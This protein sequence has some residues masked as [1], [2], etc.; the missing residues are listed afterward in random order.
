MSSSDNVVTSQDPRT[1]YTTAVEAISDSLANVSIQGD[2]T[3]NSQYSPM[4]LQ[5]NSESRPFI[6]YARSQLLFL[7]KSP[8]VRL[9]S[10]MPALKDWF[11]TE[12][13]QTNGKKDLEAPVAAGNARDRRFRRDA[14]DGAS[15][16]QSFR[17]AT[18][19]Q[20]SQMGNFKHQSIRATDRDR[21]RDA[22]R[23]QDRDKVKE[24]QERLRNLSD[25]Y[26]R[27]RRAL[28]SLSQ[29][30][31]KDRELAPHLANT[32]S[33]GTSQ[34]QQTALSRVSDSRDSSRKKEGESNE[35]WRR[36]TDQPR[37]GR[38][39]NSRRDREDRDRER[40]RS[41]V[42]DSSR[43]HRDGSSSRRD[44]DDRR[45]DRDEGYGGYRR[46]LDRDSELDDP[47]RWRDDGKRDERMAARR[48]RELRDRRDRPTWDGVDRSDRRWVAGDDRD[49]RGKKPGGRDRKVGDDSKDRED[50][51]DR[52]RE[53]EP[54]WMDTYIP[55]NN[56]GG[57]IG[58]QR[59]GGEL[60]GIQAFRKEMQQKDRSTS[61]SNADV[62]TESQV[63]SASS[64]QPPE[65]QL[66]EIQLFRLM[67][68][69]EE[70]KKKSDS[71]LI[72]HSPNTAPESSSAGNQDLGSEA[73]VSAQE[74]DA[75]L[76]LAPALSNKGPSQTSSLSSARQP[77]ESAQLGADISPS[78]R[79]T[80]SPQPSVAVTFSGQEPDSTD[81]LRPSTSRLFST[82]L[83]S[84]LPA[85][86]ATVKPSVA[87]I[88]AP[89]HVPHSHPP[90]GSRLLALSS[91]TPLGSSA[92]S[93]SSQSPVSFA[94]KN[95]TIGLNTGVVAA[96]NLNHHVGEL[97]SQFSPAVE[98]VR[99]S[100]GFSP[101]DE[102]RDASA[103]STSPDTMH[104]GPVA[105]SGDRRVFA[106][107][108]SL[109]AEPGL[110]GGF[111]NSHPVQSYEPVGSG[112]AAAK[113]SRFAKFFDGKGR[114]SQPVGSSKGSI[115]TLGPSQPT[116]LQKMDVAGFPPSHNPDAR[117]MEDIFAMLNNSAQAQILNATPELSNL[118]VGYGSA[119]NIHAL[120]NSQPHT[121]LPSHAR[122]DSLYDSRLDDRNFVPD[123]MVP[124]LRSVPPPRSRQNSAM[125]SDF[126]EESMQFNNQRG[127]APMYQG[128]V[129]SIHL[130][131]GNMGR[132]GGLP[133]PATQFRGAPSPSH[134]ATPQRLPPGLA[135]LGGRPPHEP[136]QFG[137]S[138]IGMT[139]GGL[140]GPVH[141][142]GPPQQ[143]FNNFQ[144]PAGLGFS[145]GLPMRGPHPTAHHLQ[146]TL[147]H[148]PLQGLVP[149]G[150]LGSSQAQLLGLTA[151]GIPAGLRGPGGGFGQQGPQVQL[152]HMT[153]RQHQQPQQ[154]IPPHML[155]L[156]PQQQGFGGGVNNQPAHD[157]MAL[158][159]SGG[160][161][162]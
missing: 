82:P 66:D 149:T 135:N 18:V 116:P 37:T 108:Q 24:G 50:R 125:F 120:H 55:S 9:P 17:G 7:H 86:Q 19:T 141:T 74:A 80:S 45:T 101:F 40:P 155:S 136:N 41:R 114:D 43:P 8:L 67:M 22:D 60:D 1:Q 112:I 57:V 154:Q 72:P 162:D 81:K 48:E 79:A 119:S 4:S 100:N 113:G 63:K 143:S 58:V 70:E 148:N 47:R 6:V 73:C 21:D 151:N 96:V 34:G 89:N 95:G 78:A 12:N 38:D 159:M 23:E 109:T 53:K 61:P 110:G 76:I 88:T 93:P 64:V 115:G 52:E 59:P 142:S 147:G 85:P 117:A 49:G 111:S 97:P 160:R 27:D 25:K 157:L 123:G 51:R 145:G 68:K 146:G 28:S 130:Q 42:E 99:V 98:S 92:R 133:M 13:D 14:E 140:H 62:V 150:N 94:Q 137:S 134:L 15:A 91:R 44:R 126:P 124:G 129:P 138:S 30:R 5:N 56:N 10:G 35:D 75:T 161:R 139:N 107:E 106:A 46:D 158:L 65:S 156:H 26:D 87:A 152:P 105:F 83:S 103:L 71:P 144:Q 104:R 39:Q 32:G 36:G 90:A 118:D 128:P 153:M 132:G 3:S 127:P 29:M 102:H 77:E 122:L 33:R 20:P 2:N 16:R 31:P 121:H 11:G 69:R 54:A 84:D 131:H